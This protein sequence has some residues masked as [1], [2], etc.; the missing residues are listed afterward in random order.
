MKAEMLARLLNG[1]RCGK[2]YLVSCPAHEDRNPS[3]SV[4]D[5]RHGLVVH[6]FAGCSSHDVMAALPQFG[7]EI[8][9]NSER[10]EGAPF[11]SV[12]KRR[13]WAE[14]QWNAAEPVFGSLVAK[15]LGSR[16]LDY[17]LPL[18]AALRCA[19]SLKH[20][21]GA[22]CPAMLGKVI[23]VNGEFLGVHRTFLAR[24]GQGKAVIEPNKMML[25]PCKG[26]SVRLGEAIDFVMV[27]EGIE[28]CIAAMQMFGQPAW[29]A[30]SA[31]GLAALQLPEYV[32]DVLVLADRDH[33]GERAAVQA[34]VRWRAQGRS[35]DVTLPSIGK[36]FDD[37]RRLTSEDPS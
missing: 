33:V 36:D 26:G 27:G 19:P 9:F 25:G 23:G 28:T 32:S 5:G 13:G 4:R 30:L 14:A 2:G 35:V 20:P 18:S 34:A 10:S 1:K 17:T 21:T 16:G 8:R 7:N 3:L 37:Y 12:T 24:D 11:E 22:R 15:Y 29:A 6:C 31:S